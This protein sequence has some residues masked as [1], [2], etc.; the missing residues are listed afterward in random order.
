MSFRPLTI[1]V[2]ILLVLELLRVITHVSK[3]AWIIMA[4]I[5]L[6]FALVDLL[7]AVPWP[8]RRPPA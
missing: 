2:I 1:A 4:V 8:Q 7:V 6:V 5:A 3:T